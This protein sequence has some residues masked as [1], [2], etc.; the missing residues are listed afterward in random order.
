MNCP[1]QYII[2]DNELL[3]A[4]MKDEGDKIERSRRSRGSSGG[5]GGHK[6]AEDHDEVIFF[7]E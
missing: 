7:G 1:P 4:W 2:D 3:D 6:R 5:Q